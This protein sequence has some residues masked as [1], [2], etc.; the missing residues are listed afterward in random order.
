MTGSRDPRSPM[1]I[2]S[3]IIRTCQ[4][5]FPGVEPHPHSDL[6]ASWPLVGAQ[7]LLCFHRRR[8]SG[9][10]RGKGGKDHVTF[11]AYFYTS[12]R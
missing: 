10:R 4:A 2:H 8:D 11:G 7:P 5:P 9:N 1:H 3:H 6:D 12:S